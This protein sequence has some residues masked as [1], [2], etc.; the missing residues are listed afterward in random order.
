MWLWAWAPTAHSNGTNITGQIPTAPALSVFVGKVVICY[1]GALPMGGV[2]SPV[3]F[4]LN[5]ICL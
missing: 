4:T 1:R 5:V 2:I 3:G